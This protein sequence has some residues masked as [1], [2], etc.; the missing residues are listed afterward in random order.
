MCLPSR[1]ELEKL[2]TEIFQ[3]GLER[4]IIEYVQKQAQA[5]AQVRSRGNSG[6]YLPTLIRCKQERLRA[7]ILALAD[8]WVQ[9]GTTYAVPLPRLAEEALEKATAQMT[10]GTVSGFRGE[11]EL[12]AKRT[13]TPYSSGAGHREIESAMKSALREAKLRLETQRIRA[14][15]LLRE[16]GAPNQPPTGATP[17]MSLQ[18]DAGGNALN[19]DKQVKTYK[20]A[21]ARNIDRLRKECGWTFEQLAARTGLDKKLILGHVNQGKRARVKTLKVYADAFT[22]ELKRPVKVSDLEA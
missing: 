5:L 22:K 16:V 11:V 14:E 21:P 13:R 20:T 3:A 7:E 1:F 10:A 19:P 8:A 17:D 6:G 12:M 9:A 18:A 2:A 4:R 15:R